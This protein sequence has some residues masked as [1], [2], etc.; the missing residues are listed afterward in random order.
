MKMETV[1]GPARRIIYLVSED[2]YFLSHRLPMARAARDAGFEVHVATR[3]VDGRSAIEAEKFT[4]HP[5]TWRRGT[6]NPLTFINA[7]L[8]VRRTYQSVKPDLVHMVALWPAIVGS[9]AAL[10][11]PMK[12]L[13]ALT[14]LGFAF[15]SNALK[16]R[17]ARTILKPLLRRLLSTPT[18]TVLVQNPDDIALMTDLGVDRSNLFL[19]AGSGVD[20][21]Y[22]RPLPEPNGPVT[23]GYA[24]RL[25]EDKGLRTL[26]AGQAL[27]TAQGYDVRLLIAG[28]ADAANP[29]TIPDEEIETWRGQ[30]GVEVLGRVEDIRTLWARANIAVLPSRREGLPLSLLEAAACGRAMIAA[31]VPGSREIVIPN[32]TGELVPVDDAT[33]LA[34]AIARVA[35]LPELRTRYGEAARHLVVEKFSADIIGRSIVELYRSLAI[36]DGRRSTI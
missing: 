9:L 4:L 5:L 29:G 18:A 17:V 30:R 36:K 22:L 8:E 34:T 23:I 1:D 16:A 3:I 7:I 20:T 33:A 6:I 25:L 27:L 21:D 11:L 35:G 2:W 26:L 31:D 13:S 24:G 19:I 14:G 32:V 28:E 15:T 10:G 12:R